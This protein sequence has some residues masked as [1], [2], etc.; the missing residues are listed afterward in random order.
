MNKTSSTAATPA[1]F[2]VND[3]CS[4]HSI[5]RALFYI[6]QRNGDGPRVMKVRGRTLV[7][8]ESAA[9]WRQRMEGLGA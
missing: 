8:A 1:A 6:L 7:S 5:S 3:F 4:A 2:G 9:E